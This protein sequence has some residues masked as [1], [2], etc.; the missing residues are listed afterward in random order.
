MILD[1]LGQVSLTFPN[2]AI[3][4]YFKISAT[5]IDLS[6]GG[7]ANSSPLVASTGLLIARFRVTTNY[8]TASGAP[9]AQLHVIAAENAALTTNV[10][11]LGT[12]C[13]TLQAF[14]ARFGFGFPTSILQVQA[15]PGTGKEGLE[16]AAEIILSPPTDLLNPTQ[17]FRKLRYLGA[18]ITVLNYDAGGATGFSAGAMTCDFL[19]APGYSHSRH[20]QFAAGMRIA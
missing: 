10:V 20:K 6:A 7:T 15:V 12:A 4:E 13:G 3:P 19:L 8:A 17:D 5:S 18:A 16:S 14:G 1:T 11:V 2:A 9:G